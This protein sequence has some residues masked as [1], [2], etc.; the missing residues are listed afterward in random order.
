M[1]SLTGSNVLS[2]V[3]SRKAEDTLLSLSAS[4]EFPM[5]TRIQ[6]ANKLSSLLPFTIKVTNLNRLAKA[7]GVTLPS[8]RGPRPSFDLD[9]RLRRIEDAIT[10]ILKNFG[11]PASR[12]TLDQLK[13]ITDNWL[14]HLS[15]HNTSED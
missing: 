11:V 7:V 1:A 12:G 9:L 4:P 15:S 6:V 14:V 10:F 2:R 13:I 5:M 8:N 3:Q